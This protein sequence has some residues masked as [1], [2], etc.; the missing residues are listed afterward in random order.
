VG[1]HALFTITCCLT[2]KV[3]V[4]SY[5]KN[6]GEGDFKKFEAKKN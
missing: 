6:E 5:N 1:A 2:S 4:V 3:H